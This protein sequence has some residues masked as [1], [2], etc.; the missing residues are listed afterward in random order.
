MTTT[1]FITMIV[2]LIVMIII[3]IVEKNIKNKRIKDLI[4]RN[5]NLNEQ[6]KYLHGKLCYM[7]GYK[8]ALRGLDRD[9]NRC[10]KEIDTGEFL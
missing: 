1:H 10:L 9:Y 6:N 4:I 7:I 5:E 3:E 2:F 8:H